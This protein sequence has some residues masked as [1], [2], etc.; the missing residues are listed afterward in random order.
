MRISDD[1]SNAMLLEG[2]GCSVLGS[3]LLYFVYIVN[4]QS[5]ES[6]DLFF[7]FLCILSL[8]GYAMIII[9]I[10]KKF[11][12]K[13]RSLYLQS[14]DFLP[15]RV[16]FNF[17]KPQCNFVCGYGDIKNL[18]MVFRTVLAETR[19]GVV[20]NVISKII[21]N[22]TVLNNRE[23]TLETG[24]INHMK[25]IYQVFDCRNKVGE[26]SYKYVGVGIVPQLEEVIDFYLKTGCKKKFAD[27]QRKVLKRFAILLLALGLVELFITVVT[28]SGE[29]ELFSVVIISVLLIP[30][31]VLFAALRSD[32]PLK[33]KK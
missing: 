4:N 14:V 32:K 17:N 8:F 10:I 2:I 24:T 21:L 1:I 25:K 12:D 22:F 3:V 7:W 20:Y 9:A 26:F 30:A 11:I 29:I 33:P 6:A 28:F 27:K 5:I 15:D 19:Y 18:E 31:F 23:F 16:C 13:Y